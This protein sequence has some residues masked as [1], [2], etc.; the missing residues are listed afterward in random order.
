MVITS[1]QL[2]IIRASTPI[3]WTKTM[4]FAVSCVCFPGIALFA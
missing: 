4:L 2:L 1:E 3:I